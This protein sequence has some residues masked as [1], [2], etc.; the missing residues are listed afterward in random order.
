MRGGSV[1]GRRLVRKLDRL[2]DQVAGRDSVQ[3]AADLVADD[4]VDADLDALLG[5]AGATAHEYNGPRIRP[6]LV[7]LAARAAGAA[8][9]DPE[10]QH[11]VEL[12][13]RAIAVHDIALGRQGGRRRRAARRLLQ[14]V[15]HLSGH[16][17]TIRALELARHSSSPNVL[18][19]LI[20]TLREIADGQQLAEELQGRNALPNR[21]DWLEHANTHTGALYA[22]CC[23]AG[24]SMS[25]ADSRLASALGRYGRHLGRLWHIAE[26]LDALHDPS[27]ETV[28]RVLSGRPLYPV[29]S[30][31]DDAAVAEAWHQL[32]QDPSTA[33]V[34]ALFDRVEAAGGVVQ[35]RQQVLK[36]SWAATARSR[37]CP[38]PPTGRRWPAWRARTPARGLPRQRVE[39]RVVG[40]RVP[41]QAVVPDAADDDLGCAIDTRSSRRKHLVIVAGTNDRGGHG[42]DPVRH[43][44][45]P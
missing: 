11:S 21:E 13:H 5:A 34:A 18:V 22:F 23:R 26:D 3:H 37:T 7:A 9:V 10:L 45:N 19:D 6:V 20:D 29:A 32:T 31:S 43:L 24:A 28:E 16:Q 39:H 1:R 14:R 27:T 15:G 25:G 4:L 40:S 38:R 8:E 41:Q 12:L 2:L 42:I 35:A 30:T 44:P 36:E 33:H 17:M